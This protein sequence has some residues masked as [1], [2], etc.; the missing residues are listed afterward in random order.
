MDSQSTTQ[1]VSVLSIFLILIVVA[2]IALISFLVYLH[3]KEKREKGTDKNENVSSNEKNTKAQNK[4]SI[5]NF[6]ALNR[7]RCSASAAF[8]LSVVGWISPPLS[9]SFIS[10]A[11]L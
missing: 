5:F 9:G 11:C 10:G 2:I 4:Q 7:L 6:M 8:V 1:L 3:F